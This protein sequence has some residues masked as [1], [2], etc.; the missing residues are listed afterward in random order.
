MSSGRCAASPFTSEAAPAHIP[1]RATSDRSRGKQGGGVPQSAGKGGAR[2][3][4]GGH[5]ALGYPAALRSS[6]QPKHF[7]RQAAHSS[8]SPE[9]SISPSI[10]TENTAGLMRTTSDLPAKVPAI[11]EDPTSRPCSSVEAGRAPS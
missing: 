1:R 3:A 10:R 11:S 5:G 4:G 8:D 2:K 7:Q 9:H 6:H